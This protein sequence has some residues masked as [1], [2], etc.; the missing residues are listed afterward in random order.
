MKTKRRKAVLN[1]KNMH[2]LPKDELIKIKG[3]N[4]DE[5]QGGTDTQKDG[6]FD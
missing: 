1:M 4:E 5:Y 6:E 3:G 2:V